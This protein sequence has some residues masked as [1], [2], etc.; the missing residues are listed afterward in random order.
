LIKLTRIFYN[1]IR[2]EKAAR[3]QA[4]LEQFFLIFFLFVILFYAGTSFLFSLA[5]IASG[6]AAHP[7]SSQTS[8]TSFQSAT[9]TPETVRPASGASQGSSIE[10]VSLLD[11]AN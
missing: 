4:A 6:P 9:L 5:E 8:L 3:Q 7:A 2:K 1:N 11:G 10:Y